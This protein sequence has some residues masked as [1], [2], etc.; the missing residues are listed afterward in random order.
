MYLECIFNIYLFISL[1]CTETVN[2]IKSGQLPSGICPLIK[3]IYGFLTQSEFNTFKNEK[4][5]AW[6]KIKFYAQFIFTNT[7]FN[8]T[9]NSEQQMTKCTEF[10]M[11]I[12][13][14]KLFACLFISL[15]LRFIADCLPT[16]FQNP[17]PTMEKTAS[18]V[19]RKCSSN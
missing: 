12:I 14:C 9:T 1:Q 5:Q 10:K 2:I 16:L 19:C 11:I 18:L 7:F 17:G 13:F 4:Y 3:E 8:D 15:L 6:L